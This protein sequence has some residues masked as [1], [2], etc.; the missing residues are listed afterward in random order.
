[1]GWFDGIL[2]GA[3][4]PQQGGVLSGVSVQPP[5]KWATGLG[6]FGSALQD[7]GSSLSGRGGTNHLS[8]FTTKN[9]GLLAQQQLMSALSSTDPKVRAQGYTTAAMMGIDTK[10]IQQQQAAQQA[11][12]FLK[13]L[14]AHDVNVAPVSA[15]L[16]NG[17]TVD[18]GGFNFN[19]PAMTLPEAV[20]AAPYETQQQYAPEVI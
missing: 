11:P 13:S 8:D 5:P 3:A 2:G 20:Q 6:M 4:A 12:D 7:A 10:P 14:S 18:G 9:R 1:M 19:A 15:Q 17:Q 16:P